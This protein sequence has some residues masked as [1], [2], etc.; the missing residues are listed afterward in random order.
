MGSKVG[1]HFPSRFTS[2]PASPPSGNPPVC[3]A[4]RNLSLR[5]PRL[6]RLTSLSL[7]LD[8][9]MCLILAKIRTPASWPLGPVAPPCLKGGTL[10][11]KTCCTCQN[12]GPALPDVHEAHCSK[13]SA[14][15]LSVQLS[16]VCWI[17]TQSTP[18]SF[19][20]CDGRHHFLCFFFFPPYTLHH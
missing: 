11:V 17:G 14:A 9:E 5:N 20:L 16:A 19:S 2:H 12:S 15:A 1:P 7:H 3:S 13:T 10:Q 6:H 4:L 8:C 18:L